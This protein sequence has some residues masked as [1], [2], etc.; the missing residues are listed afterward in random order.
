MTYAGLLKD[1][2]VPDACRQY[3]KSYTTGI[4][5]LTC[6]IGLDCPPEEIG[7]TDSFNLI[8][9]SL[10]AN[11]DFKNAY[12]TDTKTDPIVATCYTIDDPCVS[13]PG[14]SI[15]TAGTLKYGEAW[16]KLSPEEYHRTKYAAA[17]EIVRRLETR[18]PGLRGHI[19][20]MEVATPLTHMRYLGHPGGAIYGYEQDLKSSVFFFPQDEFIPGLTFAG[21]W[22]NTCG[23]GPNYAYGDK[24]AQSIL[25][26][27]R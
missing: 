23:F 20:E 7:F 8:Y 1:E 6:F 14:T 19:E 21:G 26:E 24:I 17:D 2:E 15:I 27:G 11:K 16:E 5:A 4:S 9:D 22:V 3:F 13:P 18:F 12:F 25:K 10:D